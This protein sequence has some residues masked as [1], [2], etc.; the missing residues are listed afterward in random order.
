MSEITGS[1]SLNVKPGSANALALVPTSGSLPQET[2][3]VAVAGDLIAKVS[4]GVPPY[5]YDIEGL[6]AGMSAT[7][8]D[9]GDGSFSVEATGTPAAGASTGGDGAGNYT[10][11][12][13][14]KD[15]ATAAAASARRPLTVTR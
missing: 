1:F 7:E 4:G 10:V 11:S 14:V 15:S 8:I 13:D 2:E 9:N 3:G 12:V 5:T 6:P